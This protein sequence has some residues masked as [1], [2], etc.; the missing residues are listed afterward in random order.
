MSEKD[1]IF[2]DP[3]YGY[4]N[5]PD[6]YCIDF[7]DTKIFQRLRRIEQTSMRVLYPSAHHDRFAHSIGV[8]HLGQT[9]FQNLKKNSASFF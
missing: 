9:A 6:K 2:R 7:I 4:I 3:I 1:K 5:I 8:Y